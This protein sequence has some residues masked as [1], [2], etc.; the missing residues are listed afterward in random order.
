[1]VSF[2]LV[3]FFRKEA[4]YSRLISPTLSWLHFENPSTKQVQVNASLSGISSNSSIATPTSPH[5]MYPSIRD[6]QQTKSARV[7]ETNKT[8]RHEFVQSKPEFQHQPINLLPFFNNIQFS[9]NWALE[10]EMKLWLRESVG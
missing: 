8:T 6:F 9:T 2:R 1:M 10:N 3:V 7:A 4:T 5:F